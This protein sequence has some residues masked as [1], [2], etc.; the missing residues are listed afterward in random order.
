MLNFRHIE[1]Y[2]IHVAHTICDKMTTNEFFSG[3]YNIKQIKVYKFIYM[4]VYNWVPRDMD[5][6]AWDQFS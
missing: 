1:K 4:Q 2:L 5:G 3:Y 6:E